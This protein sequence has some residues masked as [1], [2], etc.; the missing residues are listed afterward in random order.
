MDI[1]LTFGKSVYKYVALT[2]AEQSELS[3]LSSTVKRPQ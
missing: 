2:K 3:N 1:N